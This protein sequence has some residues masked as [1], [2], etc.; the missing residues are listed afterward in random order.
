MT[1]VGVNGVTRN[2]QI[3]RNVNEFRLWIYGMMLTQNAMLLDRLIK[4][5]D[6][7]QHEIQ[8]EHAFQRVT[9]K[10]TAKLMIKT[11]KT[12]RPILNP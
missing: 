8:I 2:E 6:T 4:L 3:Y 9:P 12:D 5:Y 11:A 7:I 1:V 10:A